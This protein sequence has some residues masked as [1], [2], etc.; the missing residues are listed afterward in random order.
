MIRSP[1]PRRHRS[2]FA[3]LNPNQPNYSLLSKRDTIFAMD[4]Q[5]RRL[6]LSRLS[7]YPQPNYQHLNPMAT[8]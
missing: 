4:G 7:V 5:L 6:R 2:H 1:T 8:L 3:T